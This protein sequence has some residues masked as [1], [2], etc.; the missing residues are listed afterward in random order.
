MTAVPHDGISTRRLRE[1]AGAIRSR[2]G[3]RVVRPGATRKSAS[4]PPR[5]SAAD[6]VGTAQ[7]VGGAAAIPSGPLGINIGALNPSTGIGSLRLVLAGRRVRLGNGAFLL[8]VLGLLSATLVALLILNTA[9]AENS[10]QLQDIRQNARELTVREQ[11]LSGQLASAESPIGLEKRAKELGMVAAGSP[12]FLRLSDGKVLGE[13]SPAEAPAPPAK[14]KAPKVPAASGQY[15]G[16]FPVGS[17]AVVGETPVGSGAGSVGGEVPVGSVPT[18][19][20][21]SE[22]G[23]GAPVGGELPVGIVQGATR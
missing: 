14:P 18:T 5:A 10:F 7:S 2:V 8:L 21:T 4:K 13:S 6:S 11:I 17:G 23:A 15:A 22:T 3:S 16:E 1:S 9:L 19:G 12:V 20:L